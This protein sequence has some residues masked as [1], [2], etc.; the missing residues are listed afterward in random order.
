[1]QDNDA[2]AGKA[3][4]VTGATSGIGRATGIQVD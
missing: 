1:M 3:V 4:L 2:F